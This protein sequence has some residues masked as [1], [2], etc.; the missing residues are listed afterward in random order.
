MV[1]KRNLRQHIVITCNS[2]DSN[3]GVTNGEA[4][5]RSAS[6]EKVDIPGFVTIGFTLM[7]WDT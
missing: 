7:W 3:T 5:K 4:K 1:Y 6:W 2:I